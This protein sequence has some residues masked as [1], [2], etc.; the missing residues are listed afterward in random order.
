[1]IELLLAFLLLYRLPESQA[2]KLVTP[3]LLD[4]REQG[5]L[6]LTTGEVGLVYGTVGILLLTIGGI[7]GG[8]AVARDGLRRWLWP[9]ALAIHLPNLAFLFLSYYQPD[10]LAAITA[11]IAVEQF[12]DRDFQI[13]ASGGFAEFATHGVLVV[14]P[15]LV[16]DHTIRI[17]HEDFRRTG[18]IQRFHNLLIDVFQNGKR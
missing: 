8:I 5:G 7:L 6:A 12:I 13:V 2:I 14:H 1:M 11:A 9:M 10:N 15:S 17:E 18:C 3:F 4:P 16:S